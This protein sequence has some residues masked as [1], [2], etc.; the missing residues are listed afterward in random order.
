MAGRGEHA[1]SP[2]GAPTRVLLRKG[3]ERDAHCST[4]DCL[5]VIVVLVLCARLRACRVIPPPPAA[6]SQLLGGV[7]RGLGEATSLPDIK[8]VIL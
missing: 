5:L 4:L 6:T 3:P 2:G 8:L 7:E 1:A